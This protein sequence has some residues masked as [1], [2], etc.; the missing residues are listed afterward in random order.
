MLY[1]AIAIGTAL[2]FAIR[3]FQR[4]RRWRYKQITYLNSKAEQNFLNQINRKLPDNLSVMCKV[5]L[6][7]LCLPSDSSNIA[8]FN[9]VSRKHVDF[10]LIEKATSK[11]V[12]AIELDDKSHN[13][14]GAMKRDREKDHALV[15]AGISLHRIAAT[16]NYSKQINERLGAI[17]AAPLKLEEESA[18]PMTTVCPR[19]NHTMSLVQLKLWQQGKGYYFCDNCK[20]NTEPER[21]N[22]AGKGA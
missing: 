19:C 3:M 7:D 5:R 12:C 20:F 2:F 18:I 21:I 11:I 10:V 13:S 8:A 14:Y 17:M 9:K 1:A 15:S 6:A 4:N 16:R 22:L